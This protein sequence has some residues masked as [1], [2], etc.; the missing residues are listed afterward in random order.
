[1]NLVLCEVELTMCRSRAWFGDQMRQDM[2]QK[3]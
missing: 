2:I 1:M 3:R